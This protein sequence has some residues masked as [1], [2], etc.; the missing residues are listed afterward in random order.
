MAIRDVEF[1]SLGLFVGQVDSFVTS[2]TPA[3]IKGVTNLQTI[4]VSTDIPLEDVGVAGRTATTKINNEAPTV[5][6]D[7]TY[8]SVDL[9]NESIL[10]F[11]VDSTASCLSRILTRDT[12]QRNY[13][14]PITDEGIDLENASAADYQ[15]LAIGNGYISSYST[16][17]SVGSFVQSTI[18]IQGSNVSAHADGVSEANPAVDSDGYASAGT[19]TLPSGLATIS[20]QT[21]VIGQGDIVLEVTRNPENALFYNPTG[22]CLQGY[23]ISFD[24]GSATRQC[25]GSK[26]PNSRKPTFPISV[27]FS[28]D[29][30]GGDLSTGALATQLCNDGSK[31]IDLAVSLH[32]P[33]CETTR[34]PVLARYELKNA[35]FQGFS[36]N[37]SQGDDQGQT[38]TMN[39]QGSI[40]ASGDTVNGLF[41]SGAY[42]YSA[43]TPVFSS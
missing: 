25:L 34:G 10:G 33:N 35:V 29:A 20:G 22:L 37:A 36:S 9:Y 7:L 27:D 32:T 12:D 41:F 6:I 13:F 11:T 21:S 4:N 3:N 1:S 19:F 18:G 15:V 38:V 42:D 26:F 30:L 28:I 8:Y 14:I 39:Y 24:L 5:S 23:N 31:N 16:E 43:G 2:Q 17:G 40:S